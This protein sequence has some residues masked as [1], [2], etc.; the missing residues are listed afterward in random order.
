MISAT[1]RFFL[2]WINIKNTFIA[3]YLSDED[4]NSLVSCIILQ[5]LP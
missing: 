2:L 4:Y 3:V 1:N 5:A